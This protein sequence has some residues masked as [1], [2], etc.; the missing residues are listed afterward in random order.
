MKRYEN[1]DMRTL[2]VSAIKHGNEKAFEYFYTAEYLNLKYFVTRYI[3]EPQIVEDI[4]Q[5]SF[6]I[7]WESREKIDTELNLKSFLFTIARN[8]AINLLRKREYNLKDKLEK[9]ENR[10]LIDTLNDEQMSSSID[11]LDMERTIINTY[12]ILPQKIRKIFILSRKEGLSYKEIS[13]KLGI[14]EKIVEHNISSALKIF[15]K[16]L[17]RFLLLIKIFVG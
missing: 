11:A 9:A 1:T 16:K 14:S 5:D 12:E 3:K 2:F 7:I 10:F 15:R 8:K 6:L 4:V 17:G 13:V